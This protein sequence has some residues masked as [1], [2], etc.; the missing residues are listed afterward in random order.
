MRWL[1][2]WL[3]DRDSEADRLAAKKA[4]T[5]SARN[6]DRAQAKWREVDEVRDE[7]TAAF[8]RALRSIR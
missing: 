4:V 6:A 1:W 3:H 2:F 7:F 5:D 8:E